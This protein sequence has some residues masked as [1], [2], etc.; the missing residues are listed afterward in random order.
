MT[1]GIFQNFIC[2]F[3]LF[4]SRK[5]EGYSAPSCGSADIFKVLSKYSKLLYA[6]Q[7]SF[8]ASQQ[9]LEIKKFAF[10]LE[11]SVSCLTSTPSQFL[12]LDSLEAD[13]EALK[14]KDNLK[15]IINIVDLRRN[16]LP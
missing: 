13:Q 14:L 2:N 16:C 1:S 12:A 11:S 5:L 8:S 6:D 15:D 4:I 3:I 7:S 10:E 9:R